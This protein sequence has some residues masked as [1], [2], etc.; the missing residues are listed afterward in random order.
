LQRQGIV[1]LDTVSKKSYKEGTL[2]M[3]LLRDNL[4]LWTWDIQGHKAETGKGGEN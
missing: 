1:E 2:T 4:T 3:Q